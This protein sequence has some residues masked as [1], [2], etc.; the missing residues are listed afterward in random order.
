MDINHNHTTPTNP[1]LHSEVGDIAVNNYLSN[2]TIHK[3]ETPPKETPTILSKL[4]KFFSPLKQN[5]VSPEDNHITSSPVHVLKHSNGGSRIPNGH[6]GHNHSHVDNHHHLSSSSSDHQEN[7]NHHNHN[8]VRTSASVFSMS[9]SE[10]E[11]ALLEKQSSAMSIELKD[12][13]GYGGIRNRNRSSN[14]AGSEDTGSIATPSS[15]NITGS[16]TDGAG[17]KSNMY[18]DRFFTIFISLLFIAG[19]DII[20]TNN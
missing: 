15:V 16:G 6:A 1:H 8:H 2:G 3:A 18:F 5:H 10:A 9:S 4:Q 13:E 12:I 14:I 20:L 19:C 17:R 11:R 7:V